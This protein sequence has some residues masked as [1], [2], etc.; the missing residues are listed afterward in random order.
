MRISLLP[1]CLCFLGGCLM[2]AGNQPS[3]ELSVDAATQYNHR[4][5]PQNA[6]G[7]VQPA[8]SI[9]LP[10]VSEGS[11]TLTTWANMDIFDDVGDAWYPDGNAWRFSEIDYIAAYSKLFGQTSA[12]LGVQNYNIPRGDR[13]P[14]GARGATTEVFGRAEYDLQDGWFPF[15]ELRVDVDEAKGWYVFAGCAKSI[16]IDAKFT[17]E[18]EAYASYMNS[19]QGFWNY[20]LS[21]AGFA[22]A[23]LTTTLFYQYDDSTRFNLV[24]AFSTMIDSNYRDEFSNNDI[25]ADN[26]WIATGVSWSY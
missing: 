23:R 1:L 25:D 5:M 13:F 12:T 3:V 20:G 21:E 17:F 15:G 6:T 2:P 8:G 9:T 7:V 19:Q 24:A 22:D 14:F 26:A 18:A 10:S 4:G 11:M 16:P